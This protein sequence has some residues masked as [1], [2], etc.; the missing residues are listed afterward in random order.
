MTSKAL[1]SDYFSLASCRLL[2]QVQSILKSAE[3]STDLSHITRHNIMT[4]NNLQRLSESTNKAIFSLLLRNTLLN[5]VGSTLCE[6]AW[7]SWTNM[8]RDI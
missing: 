1:S 5:V 4:T 8:H 2:Q 7:E 6:F 3:I